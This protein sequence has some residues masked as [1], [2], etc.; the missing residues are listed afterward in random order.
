M[1]ALPDDAAKAP[2]ITVG[3]ANFGLYPMATGQSRLGAA[4][5]TSSRRWTPC[6]P[7]SASRWTP[8]PPCSWAW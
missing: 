7:P 2:K 6:A 8:T 5:T 4:S 3:D 1:L